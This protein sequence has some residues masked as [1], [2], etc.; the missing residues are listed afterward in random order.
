MLLK[1]S[2]A[3]LQEIIKQTEEEIQLCARELFS[4]VDSVSKYKEY[5]ASRTAIMKNDLIETSC[6]IA[7]I[8]KGSLPTPFGGVSG[9]VDANN[10]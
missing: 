9:V 4:V 1:A 6:S 8:H 5:M 10:K 2:N 3:K 7:N